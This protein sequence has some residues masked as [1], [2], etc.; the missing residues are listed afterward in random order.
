VDELL[1]QVKKL[2]SANAVPASILS[3]LHPTKAS[4]VE[5][6]ADTT[7]LTEVDFKIGDGIRL[8]TIGN[9]AFVES[10][11]VITKASANTFASGGTSTLDAMTK[12]AS[13]NDLAR[14]V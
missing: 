4:I 2:T 14:P 7:K 1:T 12:Y 3:N 5:F 13:P 10:L 8:K 6:Y 11:T 9:S